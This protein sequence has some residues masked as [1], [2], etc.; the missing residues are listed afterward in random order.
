MD[1]GKVH[2]V[3]GI[4]YEYGD[5]I[6]ISDYDFKIGGKPLLTHIY[7][8]E[9]E[10]KLQF[11]AGDIFEDKHAEEVFPTDAELDEIFNIVVN[12]F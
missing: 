2:L 11:F 9:D 10:D 4:I 1:K 12:D 8:N 7:Y 5:L 3:K 6:N